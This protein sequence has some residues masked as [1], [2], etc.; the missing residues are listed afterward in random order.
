MAILAIFL[1]GIGNFAM[2]KAVLESGHPLIGKVP[3]FV[4]MIGGRATLI[5]EFLVLLAALLLAA[6]GW[7]GLAWGY[8]AYTGLNAVAAWLIISRRI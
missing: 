4:H 3:W 8:L 1:L 6:N 5:V 2:H 7:P